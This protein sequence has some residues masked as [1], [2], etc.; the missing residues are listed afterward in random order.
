MHVFEACTVKMVV[1]AW[2]NPDGCMMPPTKSQVTSRLA[3][4]GSK[5][6]TRLCIKKTQK[7]HEKTNTTMQKPLSQDAL[8]RKL[9]IWNPTGNPTGNQTY[10]IS[11]IK[12]SPA[13]NR[14]LSHLENVKQGQSLCPLGAPLPLQAVMG[15][16]IAA[17]SFAT[18]VL[19]ELSHRSGIT[20]S[21]IIK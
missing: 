16:I 7:K 21:I 17:A 6:R 2:P 4:Q 8:N 11:T 10:L 18:S 5:G 20:Y 14:I 15:S 3:A 12:H 9:E 1:C 13:G 19:A